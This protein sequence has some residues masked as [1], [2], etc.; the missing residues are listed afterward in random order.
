MFKP[1][2]HASTFGGN[3]LACAAGLAVAKCVHTDRRASCHNPSS[4]MNKLLTNL[5]SPSPVRRAI[6]EDGLLAQVTARGERLRAGLKQL[7]VRTSLR[8]KMF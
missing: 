3:P 6:E 7:Q 1:G 4:P 8:E 5:P 2:D